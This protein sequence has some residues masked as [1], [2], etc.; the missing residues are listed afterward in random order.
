MTGH[1]RKRPIDRRSRAS[2]AFEASVAA[3]DQVADR[4][5]REAARI[6][7]FATLTGQ[8]SKTSNEIEACE[9]R[10]ERLNGQAGDEAI[11]WEAA[12]AGTSITPDTPTEMRAWFSR[13]EA[14]LTRHQA[15]TT[16][17]RAVATVKREHEQARSHLLRAAAE[18]DLTV[19]PDV[20]FETLGDRVAGSYDSAKA[21]WD[22]SI[23]VSREAVSWII[24]QF[25]RFQRLLKRFIRLKL[26][27][28]FH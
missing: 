16:S 23:D 26:V 25:S 19:A 28:G 3:A 8:R 5:E 10:I 1:R 27:D 24:Q 9:K 11:E 18:Q 2:G 20:D 17:R 21:L 22:K 6:E 14:V 4:R 12:W 15:V 13:K 7:R